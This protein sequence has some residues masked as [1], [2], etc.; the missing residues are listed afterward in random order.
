MAADFVGPDPKSLWQ[1]QAPDADPVTLEQ[2]HALVRRYDH[3]AR[4][5]GVIL[6]V[7]LV[8][9]GGLGALGWVHRHDPITAVLFVGG[10]LTACYMVWRLTFPT[11]DPAEP[12]VA[13]LRRRMQL[14]LAHAQGGWV[15]ATL[16]LL[17][18]ILRVGYLTVQRHQA[19][20]SA[21]LAPFV[22]LAA[23]VALAAVRT[24]RRAREIRADLLALDA[25]LER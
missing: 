12:A 22:V 25:L 24:R 6:A 19:S 4:R 18:V 11:R 9:I 17:P 2:I 23:G 13:Y 1:D 16:P 20:L 3:R 14:K 21:Q 15:W 5:M 8:A 7:M 10:E